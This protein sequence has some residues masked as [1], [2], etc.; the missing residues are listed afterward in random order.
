[1]G[2]LWLLP[3]WVVQALH[4]A[5]DYSS[6]VALEIETQGPKRQLLG[7]PEQGQWDVCAKA[8]GPHRVGVILIE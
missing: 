3:V 6:T 4:R 8:P 7:R 5:V 2:G 1:M